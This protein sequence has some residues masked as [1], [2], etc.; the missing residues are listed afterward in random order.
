M[1][2]MMMMTTT[3]TK[4]TMTT[5]AEAKEI[6]LHAGYQFQIKEFMLQLLCRFFLDKLY[7]CKLVTS[8]PL[9]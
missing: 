4:T 8:M 3:A 7:F 1:K 2:P 9:N 5:A 6:W